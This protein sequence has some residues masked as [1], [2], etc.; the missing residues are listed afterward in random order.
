LH[1][2]IDS[3]GHK[4]EGDGEWHRRKHGGSKHCIWIKLHIVIDE[5]SE[6]ARVV[7]I[8]GN[9]VGDAL[10]LPGLLAQ[11]PKM[12]L[13]LWPRALTTSDDVM[14]PSSS[15][16]RAVIPPWKNVKPWN[17]TLSGAVARNETLRA[18][19]RFERSTLR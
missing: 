4:I 3:L 1:L 15:R 5:G 8:T 14:K 10:V 9:E 7:E 17:P 2:L 19:E 6:E 18:S 13:S 16:G 12:R 11:I